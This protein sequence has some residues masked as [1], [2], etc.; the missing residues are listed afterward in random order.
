ME[1]YHFLQVYQRTSKNDRGRKENMAADKLQTQ[2]NSKIKALNTLSN[3]AKARIVGRQ[4][5]TPI[6]NFN[7]NRAFWTFVKK[8]TQTSE[9]NELPG[10]RTAGQGLQSTCHDKR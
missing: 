3:Q 6:R 5:S 4:C 7:L 9:L 8:L 10:P 1:D 2:W